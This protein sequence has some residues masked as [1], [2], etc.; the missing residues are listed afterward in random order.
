MSLGSDVRSVAVELYL[1][2]VATRVPL[3][4]GASVVQ[5]VSVAR[6]KMTVEDRRGVR[7]EGWGETPLSVAWGW[8]STYD[9][10]ERQ[11]RFESLAR[12]LTKAWAGF[13]EQGHPLEV[14]HAFLHGE[15]PRLL[16]EHNR[17][18][19]GEESMPWLAA[20]IT[21]S[22]FDIALH[23]AFGQLH[24]R[25]VYDLYGKDWLGSDLASFLKPSRGCAVGSFQG[26]RPDAFLT[27]EPPQRLPAWH[28][29]GGL[30]PL[31]PAE[32]TGNEPQDG[33]PVLLKDWIDRDGLKCL[34]IKLRGNDPAWDYARM[35]EVGRL[36]LA[37]GVEWF[38]ADFNCTAPDAATVNESLDRLLRDEPEIYARLLYVEQPFPYDLEA[39]AWDVR[40]VSARK[41]L[42]MDE[43]AHDWE[44][45]GL[46]RD[47]GWSGVALKTCK[48]QT[49]AI[50]SACWAKAHGMPLMV[51]DLTNPM[52]AMMPH[53]QLAA[54]V[55]TIMGI[56]TNAPQFY[57]DASKPEA[58]VHP[59]L[60]R[61]QEGVVSLESLG[62]SGFGYRL[63]EIKRQLPPVD[64]A[65]A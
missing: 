43:S 46:G 65:A 22:A 49:V 20:L 54:H 45:I 4:F 33:Y 61:R 56:E 31:G 30:D 19:P 18:H 62:S 28:L 41:P 12:D 15:L 24:Q 50:L 36:G 7:A 53:V 59:R 37:S 5:Q 13:G 57:P 32:L 64:C 34:K 9:Y 21:N 52:L 11:K 2:P 47:L 55:G 51:Q 16:G 42:F 63:P 3:K 48:T 27:P 14:G 8:P 25:A 10:V 44:T 29:V 17:A 1:L 39:N 23:D 60:Y 6:V 26:L 38:S 58:E 40:S 35:V